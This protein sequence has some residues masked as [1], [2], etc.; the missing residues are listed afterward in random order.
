MP[1]RTGCKGA[2]CFKA[3]SSELYQM[4]RSPATGDWKAGHY[5]KHKNSIQFLASTYSEWEATGPRW[6]TWAFYAGYSELNGMT[7]IYMSEL[8]ILIFSILEKAIWSNLTDPEHK[9]MNTVCQSRKGF[10]VVVSYAVSYPVGVL[11]KNRFRAM[12]LI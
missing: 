11:R 6:D 1:P 5:Y 7:G 3:W 2:R 10:H 4:D 12:L 9:S 8:G